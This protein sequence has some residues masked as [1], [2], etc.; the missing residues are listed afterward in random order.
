MK[1][2]II[3]IVASGKTTLAKKLSQQYNIPYYELDCIV[4]P[5]TETGRYKRCPNEQVEVINT[6][7]TSDNWIIEGT[8]RESCHLILD[9]ADTIIFLDT[10]LWKRKIRILTRHIKQILHIELS[11]YK[12]SFHMLQ[13]MY[14]W[15]KEFENDRFQFEQMLNQYQNKL[16]IIKSNKVNPIKI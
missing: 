4:Y 16:V 5:K 2:Y 8:Y 11:H 13:C 1:I 15:T 14:R 3:G 9:I 10:P 12:P 6:I 7:N